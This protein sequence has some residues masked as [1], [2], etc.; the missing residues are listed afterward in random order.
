YLFGTARRNK[1]QTVFEIEA[2]A[3]RFLIFFARETRTQ[4]LN[5]RN[6]AGHSDDYIILNEFVHQQH[7]C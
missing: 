6:N 5:G 1:T 2:S 7:R 4:E 3:Y